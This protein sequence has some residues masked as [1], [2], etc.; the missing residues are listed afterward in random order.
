MTPLGGT[1]TTT[2]PQFDLHVGCPRPTPRPASFNLNQT[3]NAPRALDAVAD[4]LLTINDAFQCAVAAAAG[5]EAVV[6]NTYT[7]HDLRSSGTT[8]RTFTLDN[9]TAPTS[10]S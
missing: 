9:G 3:L 2:G 1:F 10:R 4:T 6:G 5:K 8:I 7:I